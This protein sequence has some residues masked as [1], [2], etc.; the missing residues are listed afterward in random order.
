V[1]NGTQSAQL[2]TRGLTVTLT[3]DLLTSKSNQLIFI[4]TTLNLSFPRAVYKISLTN[5]QYMLT[6]A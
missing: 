3:Y 6:D 5:F 1:R 4:L 2:T